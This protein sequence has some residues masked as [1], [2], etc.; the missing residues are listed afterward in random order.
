MKFFQLNRKIYAMLGITSNQSTGRLNRKTAMAFAMYSL[1]CI[2]T[3]LFLCRE[4]T[5]LSEFTETIYLCSAFCVIGL[6]FASMK[7]QT[8]TLFK[9]FE[10]FE[11]VL[12]MSMC[13]KAQIWD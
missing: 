7:I 11:D 3:G 1:G 8:K 12:E 5:T 2:S 9:F 10:T 6:A 13:S 4:A